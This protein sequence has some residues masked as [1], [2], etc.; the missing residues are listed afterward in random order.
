M[1]RVYAQ[2]KITG[3]RTAVKSVKVHGCYRSGTPIL[4]DSTEVAPDGLPDV[5]KLRVALASCLGASRIAIVVSNVMNPP[6]ETLA[7]DGVVF[8][9]RADALR[10]LT[11][12]DD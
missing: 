8:T 7:P 12:H 4:I 1:L 11:A 9:S 6:A 5:R 10:W 3:R 2:G